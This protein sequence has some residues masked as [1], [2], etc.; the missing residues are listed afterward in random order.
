MAEMAVHGVWRDEEALC[1]FSVCQSF[2]D[3][4]C[5]GELR[6]RQRRPAARLGL[7]GDEAASHAELAQAASDS[8]GIPGR[9]QLGVESEGTAEHVD[10]GI[11]VGRGELGAETFK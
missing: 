8:A 4:P 5:D 7:G 11:A 6:R 2:G 10:G 1:D 9:S 3:E